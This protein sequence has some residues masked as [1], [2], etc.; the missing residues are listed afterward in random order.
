MPSLYI[1]ALIYGVD[2]VGK[3]TLC[4][5]APNPIF[6]G[7]EKGTEQLD[8]ARFPQTESI[9][10]LFAQLASLRLRRRQGGEHPTVRRR[11]R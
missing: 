11:L 8:V 1:W 9:S 10:E 3:T 2:G 4:S 7:A 5:H 6:V